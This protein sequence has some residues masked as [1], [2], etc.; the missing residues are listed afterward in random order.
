M[1]RNILKRAAALLTAACIACPSSIGFAQKEEIVVPEPYYEFTFD[2]GVDG[3]NIQNQGTK[4][5]AVAKIGGNGEGLGIEYD[6]ERGSNVLNLPGG[7]LD[8]G[9]LT[10]PNEMFADAANEGFAFSFWMNI[11]KSASHY[12]RIFSA[13]SIELNSEGWPFNAPEFTFVV[14]GEDT[15]DTAYNTSI[16]MSDRSNQM[17]LVWKRA[18]EKGQW[19][20][21]TVSVN[22]STYDV[23]LDGEKIEVQDRN[24]NMSRILGR[25]FADDCKELKKYTHNAIGRSVYNTDGD[26]KGKIDEFRFY[27]T[28]LTA[29]QAKAAYDSYAVG[30]NM[31][32]QLEQKLAEARGYSISFY[33]KESYESLQK[34]IEEAE[35]VLVNPVTET[36]IERMIGVLGKAVEALVFY[37]GV[38]ENTAFTNTQLKA[39]T[40]EA[41]ELV[42]QSGIT[43]ESKSKLNE[44]IG[45][46]KAALEK[47]EK[48]EQSEIDEALVNLR[49][50]VAGIEYSAALHFDASKNTGEMFHGST[51]FL[52][53]VSEVNVPSAELIEAIRPK[54]LVQKAADGKQHPSGDGYR[55]TSYLDTCGVEN[56][57]IYLQDYYLEWPYE[58][59]GIEDYDAKVKKIVTKMAEGK[60]EEQLAKYSF[61]LFNEPDGIWYGN[62]I[63]RLCRD[64]KTIYTTVKSINPNLKV[65]GPNYSG[66]RSDHYRRFFEY[67]RENDCLP[68]Y[69]TWHE[70]QK[71]KL[72]SFKSH[73]DEIRNYVEEYYK[74]SKIN[75]ILFVNET[76]NFDDVGAPG[77]LVNWL[78]IFEE[79]K[80]YASLPYWGLANS[81][82][83]LAADSNKPNGAWWVYKWYAQMTGHTVP[84]TLENIGEPSAHGRLYGLTSVDDE[85]KTI[86]TLFGGQAGEQTVLIENIRA[87]ETFK[88]ADSAHVKIY[89]SKYTGHHGFADETP[90]VFEGNVRL[91]GDDLVY[92][93]PNAELMDAYYAVVTP[94]T[95]DE[96]ISMEDFVQEKWQKTY[97]AEDAVMIGNAKVFKKE[98]GGDLAR[99]NRAEAG[100]MNAEGDG[101]RFDVDVPKDGTYRMNIYYS[102]QA[103]QV[104]PMTLE[105][106][107]TKGQ[108]RAIGAISKHKLSVDGEEMQEVQYDSTVK[109]GYYNYKTVYLDLKE[110]SHTIQLTYTG[111]DQNPKEL[112]SMLCAVL[113]K[114]DLVY[115]ADE[116]ARVLVEPEELIG[117]EEG[118]EFFVNV[119]RDGYYKIDSKGSGSAVLSRSAVK[120][121]ENAKAESEMSSVWKKLMTVELGKEGTGTIYLTAGMNKLRL[122]GEGLAVDQIIFTEDTEKT[123]Q[124]VTVIE[125]EDCGLTGTEAEDGYNYLRG[126]SAVPTV[127]ENGYASGDKVVEGFRGGKDNALTLKVNVHS[128][129]DYKLSVVYAN[130][131][132]APVMKK[133]DGGNYVHPYNT[134][135]VE[136]Y[137]QISVNGGAPQ[138]VYFRNTFSWDVF[139]NVVIDVALEEGENVITF[140]NDNSYKFSEV[141]D[142]FTPRFDKFE[143]TS[144]VTKND[145]DTEKPEKPDTEKPDIEKP[146]TEEPG[147]EVPEK[148]DTEKPNTEKPDTKRPEKQEKAEQHINTGDNMDTKYD[149]AL[150][151]CM[152][153]IVTVT[154]L[155]KRK[156][157]V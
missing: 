6:E 55:L 13:S 42:Q 81:L 142:D 144:A 129:G 128:A 102:N 126:S 117:T 135:L 150:L 24:N 9:Y 121:A 85:T 139:K 130:N 36:N 131:E 143:I 134:D 30:E 132:P 10:L 38:D 146:D 105:Y 71:D 45:N 118:F 90:V 69:I 147:T 11:D 154:V 63:E 2:E 113:D 112:G 156:K 67:C 70:L 99:S 20:H 50:A 58:N 127:I 89:R 114:I 151:I 4:K 94:A 27:N 145:A 48:A 15:A 91:T 137:A 123:K 82:N 22:E 32:A 44:A 104:D 56:I 80:V 155:K 49:A 120:F 100:G 29:E 7:G 68:E 149:M 73:C 148:P 86:Q 153:G 96:T 35:G 31:L 72:T 124:N 97:E 79:E 40:E 66:Y 37:E 43:A 107:D 93:I 64:W 62:D 28:M 119:P 115:E 54:I 59:A 83:E 65:A 141:Q 138:T 108:N 98:N 152:A 78:S 87:A 52:Y 21:V 53:G 25:L 47:G 57:Q 14:G 77:Q 74:D 33:T 3:K 88:D 122:Q 8:C 18:F 46:A 60:S 39:E 17:K 133:Q 76:V 61:V 103:P 34:T 140:T 1:K 84:L 95:S 51:G 23:Y 19:Q 136:R 109:W 16:M 75:P 41:K 101:V 92:S 157:N 106:V 110:G 5:D 26:I 125:A 12:N 111:E 116:E